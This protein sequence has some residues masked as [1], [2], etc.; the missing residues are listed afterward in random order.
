MKNKSLILLFCCSVILL[1]VGCVQKAVKNID[2][3]GKNIICFGDSLTFGY[4]VNPGEDYPTAL[5]KMTSIPVI[6]AGIDSDTTAEAL[7]RLKTDCLDRDPLLAIINFGGNDFLR[8]IPIETTVE[9]IRIMTGQIQEKGAMAA[10]VD[11]SAGLFLKE[12]HQAF[13]KLAGETGAI[14]VPSILSGII[15]NPKLKSDFIHPNT[16]GYKIIAH[17]VYRAIFAYLNQNSITRDFKVN[18]G[19]LR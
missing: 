17:R 5:A 10:I 9:N 16:D 15:T 18:Q 4:G 8:K 1:S 11:I 6:N 7:K 12:Y 19:K 2:S 13:K 3:P 14:F